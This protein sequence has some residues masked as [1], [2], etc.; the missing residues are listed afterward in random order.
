MTLR[1]PISLAMCLLWAMPLW[2]DSCALKAGFQALVAAESQLLATVR[3]GERPSEPLLA[4]LEQERANLS[5]ADLATAVAG[6]D[7]ENRQDELREFL[8]D[9]AILGHVIASGSGTALSEHLGRHGAATRLSRMIRLLEGFDCRTGL[10][11]ASA[12]GDLGIP[13]LP[14]G[15]RGALYATSSAILIAAGLWS[16]Y[17]IRSRSEAMKRRY[18]VSLDTALLVGEDELRVRVNNLSRMG[19]QFTVPG[20]PPPAMGRA[21]TLR[22]GAGAVP[23]R[24]AWTKGAAAGISFDRRLKEELFQDLT[25][26]QPPQ[27]P[28]RTGR[29]RARTGS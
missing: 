9:S 15:R 26:T 1:L 21:V 20:Q 24:I 23:G 7:L 25:R 28:G 19:A 18:I 8:N 3:A 6:T 13:L 22:I 11:A 2:A 4:I 14:D 5:R 17:G 27:R 12:L 16:L 10:L 29:R